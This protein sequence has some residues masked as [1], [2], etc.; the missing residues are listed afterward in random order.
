MENLSESNIAVM[1]FISDVTSELEFLH[2]YRD[3][4]EK[5][6]S[7]FGKA[8]AE[9]QVKIHDQFM[10]TVSEFLDENL[11]KKF[12]QDQ[13]DAFY[14]AF[15]SDHKKFMGFDEVSHNILT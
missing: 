4:N 13:T 2:I 12:P 6:C 14:E 7:K 5:N 10:D 9:E 3:F 8:S 11:G 15:A 1:Q